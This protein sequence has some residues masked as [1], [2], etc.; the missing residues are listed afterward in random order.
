MSE[1]FIDREYLLDSFKDY[2]TDIVEKKIDQVNSNLSA[3]GKCKNLLNPTLQ[4]T[5]LNGVTCT[6]NVDA[7][8]KSDGTYTF[9][10]TATKEADF[11]FFDNLEKYQHL[12]NRTVK[13][14]G[15]PKG[16]SDTTYRL[17]LQLQ[18]APWPSAIDIGKGASVT[19]DNNDNWACWIR[20]YKGATVSNLTFKPMLVFDDKTPNA[21][22]D[23]FVPYTGD[24]DTLASDVAEIKKDL[25]G[26]TFSASGTALSITDGTNTWTLEAN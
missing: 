13:L 20:I 16:G 2:N 6:R 1:K 7:N 9:N 24:G 22:Y 23:D 10:G 17:M 14:V 4:T 8:G 15:C 11:T 5:T 3:L 12:K 25:G 26:L 18:K 21:T 19:V